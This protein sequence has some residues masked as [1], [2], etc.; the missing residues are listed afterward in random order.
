MNYSRRELYALG[1]T[2]GESATRQKL[3]GGYVCGGGG[4]SSSSTSSNTTNVDKRLALDSGVGISSDQSTVNVTTNNLD[5]GIVGNALD[6]VN[7]AIDAVSIADATNSQGFTQLLGLADKIFQGAGT[8][9]QNTQAT[10][11]AQVG[12][13]NTAQNDNK[14]AIDQKTIIVLAVA[15]AAAAFAFSRKK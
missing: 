3:G 1:E 5:A 15:G 4:G 10:T 7:N 8:I 2:L 6:S 11:L 9:L 12:A 14:G 13:L